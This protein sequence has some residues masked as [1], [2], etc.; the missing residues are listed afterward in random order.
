MRAVNSLKAPYFVKL[1]DFTED[2][3]HYYIVTEYL[4][5]TLL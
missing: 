5:T 4:E 3:T 2:Q 1:L